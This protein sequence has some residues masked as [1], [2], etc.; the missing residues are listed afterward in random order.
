MQQLFALIDKRAS[1][2]ASVLD[3]QNDEYY[4]LNGNALVWQAAQARAQNKEEMV[5]I[6]QLT[7]FHRQLISEFDRLPADSRVPSAQNSVNMLDYSNDL[8]GRIQKSDNVINQTVAGVLFALLGVDLQS[9]EQ[10][11]R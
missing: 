4:G 2:A 10:D 3:V 1:H 6:Y 5:R 7:H 11:S 9:S 8:I